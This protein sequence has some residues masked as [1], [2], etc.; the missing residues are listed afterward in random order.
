MIEDFES[1]YK[2]DDNLKEKI[3]NILRIYT[4][5]KYNTSKVP[6]KITIDQMEDLLNIEGDEDKIL[7]HLIHLFNRESKKACIKM[8]HEVEK[9]LTVE[10]LE[11]KHSNSLQRSG[12]E[13][14]RE[15]GS[16]LYAKWKNTLFISL[17][18]EF[19]RKESD[20]RI[21]E[22]TR[23]GNECKIIALK[24]FLIFLFLILN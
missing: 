6:T 11:K 13:F 22:S 20:R 8:K 23:F 16:P 14:D 10:R 7:S 24:C 17:N 19:L 21:L 15:T 4:V 9:E 1:I 12:L 2:K 5:E 3:E 18:K